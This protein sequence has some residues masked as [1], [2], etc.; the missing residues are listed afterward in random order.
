MIKLPFSTRP[1]G[2]VMFFGMIIV[3]I[4]ASLALSFT[5][6]ITVNQTHLEADI[7]AQRALHLAQAYTNIKVQRVWT[8][9]STWPTDK[10][11]QFVYQAIITNLDPDPSSPTYNQPLNWSEPNAGYVTCGEGMAMCSISTNDP[12]PP[13]LLQPAGTPA[14]FIDVRFRTVAVVQNLGSGVARDTNVTGS[15]SKYGMR[16]VARE[17]ERV[18]RFGLGQ[19]QVFDYVYFAN[20]FGWMYGNNLNLY[21]NM[22][23]NGNLNFSGNPKVDGALYA[24]MNPAINAAGT[25]N[26]SASFDTIKQYQTL[27]NSGTPSGVLP[28]NDNNNGLMRPTNPAAPGV[29][30]SAGYDGTQPT[31]SQQSMINMPYLSD[32]SAY[33]TMAK[34]TVLAARADLG[35]PSL[36]SGGIVKQLKAPGLDPTV[37][38][39]YNIIINHTYG[40]NSG[41]NGQYATTS[42]NAQGKTVVTLNTVSTQLDATTQANNGNLALIG[43]PEQP[44]VVLGPVVVS[45][46][47][48]IKGTITGQGTFY[49][50]RNV[51][52][53]GDLTYA[54]A[55]QWSQNDSN[56]AQTAADDT[57]KDGVGFGVKG[58]VVLGQY[59]NASLS[60]GNGSDSW[61]S[62]LAYIKPPFTAPYPVD[63]KDSNLGYVTST[64][65]GQPSFNGDYTATDGGK[66][67]A[68][69]TGTGTPIARRFYESSFSNQY[70]ATYATKPQNVQGIFYTNHY[71]GGRP[72][73]YALY[74][75]VIMRDEAILTDNLANFYYDPRISKGALNA[76]IN[77]FLPRTPT[78][79]TVMY[80]EILPIELSGASPFTPIPQTILN[81]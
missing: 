37:A 26:G 63:A 39:N 80:H 68:T 43:T 77:L 51:N 8:K 16:T 60:G 11:V 23:A 69:S 74:G 6:T 3:V 27:A 50:G 32:L 73:N 67:L 19:A 76:Y 57:K 54:N 44:I 33:Q 56:V 55:P 72:T 40:F 14:E 35:E 34:S 29:P 66:K 71:Y 49:T 81:D 18:I 21:G 58:N 41:E 53:I 20:N 22:G 61:D 4:L 62:A 9:Y 15:T 38:S 2:S 64:V 30:F 28:S 70:I 79:S 24:A 42:V 59:T 52:V 65:N 7:A 13:Q 78:Y 48:V 75:A 31:Q 36:I 47:L 1:R 12:F 5:S 45:N 46:D 25:I 10:R 17:V